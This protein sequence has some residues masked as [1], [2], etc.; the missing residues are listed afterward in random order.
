MSEVQIY[1][2][3]ESR[4]RYYQVRI[5]QDLLGDWV[6]TQQWGGRNSRLGGEKRDVVADLAEGLAHL[7]AIAKVRAAH[8]Y[9]QV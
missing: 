9:A 5:T 8:G 4:H 7:T 2:R 3:W 1:R 6:L